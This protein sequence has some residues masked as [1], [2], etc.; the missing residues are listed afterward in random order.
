MAL[1]KSASF[2]GQ[3]DV[4]GDGWAFSKG[5]E[6][7][8]LGVCYI[9]VDQLVG[10]KTQLSATVSITAQGG[11]IKYLNITFTPDLDGPNF[12]KQAYLHLKTLPEF[13]DATDC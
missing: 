12:I 6:L 2:E 7:I 3:I 13:S 5:L 8:D 4:K 1:Q 11:G 10:T 9:K